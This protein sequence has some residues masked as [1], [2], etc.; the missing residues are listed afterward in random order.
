MTSGGER[1]PRPMAPVAAGRRWDYLFSCRVVDNT[2]RFVVVA[3]QSRP[4][5]LLTPPPASRLECTTSWE[6]TQPGEPPTT[7]LIQLFLSQLTSFLTF[8]LVILSPIQ[9]G[10]VS[11]WLCG[12]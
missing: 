4:L 3:E 5:V 6:E 9:L 11:A 8:A 2:L 7:L 10:G 1:L 12:A